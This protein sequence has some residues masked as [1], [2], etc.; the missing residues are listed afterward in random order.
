MK[1]MLGIEFGSTRIKAVLAD[2]NGKVLAS[3][4]YGWENRLL[5]GGVWSYKL[6]DAL[7]GMQAAYTE[8]KTAYRKATRKTLDSLDAI[9]VSGMMHGYLPFDVRGKQLAP[10]RTWRCTI[11]AEASEKLTKAFDFTIPQRWSVAHLYQRVLDGGTELKS[12]SFLTTLAGWIHFKLTGEKVLGLGEA[13]GMFPV[14]PATKGYDAKMARTFDRLAAKKGKFPW[15]VLDVLPRPLPAGEYAGVLT[16]AG[17]KLLDPSGDLAPG[18]LAAPPEGD[19]QTG[20]VA[21][22]TVRPGTANISAGTSAFAVVALAKPLAKRHPEIDVCVSP[23][24]AQVAMSHAN[25][26]TSDINAWVALLGGD[27]DRL[28][29]E[30]LKGAPDCGGVVSVPFFGGEPV[31]GMTQNPGDAMGGCAGCPLVTRAPD[32][33]FTLANFMRAHIYSAFAAVRIG[34]GILFDEGL[35]LKGITGHGGIFKT[36]GVAQQVL[37]DAVNAPATCLETAGEGGAWGMAL[38]AAYAHATQGRASVP[39][40][41]LEDFLA[42]RIFV[43]AKGV[44]LKPTR[45]GVNGYAKYLERFGAALVADAVASKVHTL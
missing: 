35:K 14:D 11:T 31:V 27:Y 37:A 15:K 10:F 25:T 7:K 21:T 8:L 39:A 20:M 17:A 40:S 44:T 24:G 32:A 43:G 13:S 1:K 4:S 19:V 3:G 45:A 16:E 33:D 42:K 9:G 34:L 41:R 22:N 18:A 29:K 26:C 2:E 23:T 5:S 36:P 6:E 12:L 28:F 30:A 38:L